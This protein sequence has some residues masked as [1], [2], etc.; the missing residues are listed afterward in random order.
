[1]PGPAVQIRPVNMDFHY[2]EAFGASAPEAYERLIL[3]CLLGE[4]ALFT[5]NDEVE[6]AW[7]FVNR[8]LEGWAQTKVSALPTYEAGL[9][10]PAEAHEF[11]ERDGRR[12]RRL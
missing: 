3:D 4:A 1:V 10:G 2:A 12:W 9:W 7:T 8:I 11:I 6:A 5:R